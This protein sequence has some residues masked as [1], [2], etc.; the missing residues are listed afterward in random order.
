MTTLYWAAATLA[1]CAIIGL[2]GLAL[3]ARAERKIR[4][5]YRQA[6][7]RYQP[8]RRPYN[9]ADDPDTFPHATPPPRRPRCRR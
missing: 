9:W 6:G 2:I 7:V 4:D 1:G 5:V 3:E 8:Q